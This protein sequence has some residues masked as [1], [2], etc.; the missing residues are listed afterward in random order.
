M[1][2][3]SASGLFGL[4]CSSLVVGV[5]VSSCGKDEIDQKKLEGTWQLREMN[6]KDPNGM[7]KTMVIPEQ[8]ARTVTFSEGKFVEGVPSGVRVISGN[9]CKVPRSYQIEGMVITIP[10]LNDGKT[11]CA[12]RR[13]EVTS[14]D[15]THLKVRAP[16][17]GSH[18]YKKISRR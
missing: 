4:V 8:F 15:E 3:L 1:R 7:M 14:L 11:R 13:L 17:D 9:F 10:A 2:K 12:E 6:G 5:L 18:V 16:G